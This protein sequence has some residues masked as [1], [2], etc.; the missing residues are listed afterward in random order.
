[1]E[2]KDTLEVSKEKYILFQAVIR[3]VLSRLIDTVK[4]KGG[5]DGMYEQLNV[6][7][8]KS[9]VFTEYD[10]AMAEL[11]LKDVEAEEVA[12][13]S[14][15]GYQAFVVNAENFKDL[16][17]VGFKPASLTIAEVISSIQ[18]DGKKSW[19]NAYRSISKE[20]AD[21]IIGKY[22]YDQLVDGE[23]GDLDNSMSQEK[24]K[25]LG[26]IKACYF[27]GKMIFTIGESFTLCR[28]N[29]MRKQLQSSTF[30]QTNL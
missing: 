5:A 3:R 6:E 2:V 21:K 25:S 24:L 13:R 18:Q 20:K 11:F 27:T 28:A 7:L 15:V 12:V 1:M 16:T 23:Y 26:I 14:E 30:H 22:T 29:V 4:K 8:Y 10:Q 9:P 17:K 19:S